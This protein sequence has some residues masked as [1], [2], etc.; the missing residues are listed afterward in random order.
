M[1]NEKIG[2]CENVVTFLIPP[3]DEIHACGVCGGEININKDQDFF[4]NNHKA[5]IFTWHKACDIGNS[6]LNRSTLIRLE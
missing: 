2:T 1:V 3:G 5:G 4:V 6:N